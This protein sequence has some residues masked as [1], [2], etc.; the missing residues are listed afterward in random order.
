MLK[1]IIILF[2]TLCMVCSLLVG[3]NKSNN[4]HN[5]MK[6]SIGTAETQT[7]MTGDETILIG[8]SASITGSAPVNGLR[9]QQGVQLAVDEI[10]AA[11]GVLGK[12]LELF[13]ADDGGVQDTAINAINLILDQNIVAQVGPNLSGLTLAIESLMSDAGVPFLT[14][15]TSPKLVTTID[16]EYLFRIRASDSIQAKI[17]TKFI[18][19]NLGCKKIG[20]LTDSDDYGAGALGVAIEY[21]EAMGIEYE[22]QVFNTGDIDLTSQ[23]QKLIMAGVDGVI[24]WAHD[25]ETAL[26]AQ[27]FYN[28]GLD[29]PIVGSTSISTQQVIDLCEKEWLTNWYSVTDFTTTNPSEIVQEFVTNFSK[30]YNAS[31]ELYAAT[32]YSSIYILKDAIERARSTDREEIRQALLETNGFTSVLATYTTNEKRE[33]VHQGIICQIRGGQAIYLD[34]V[35]SEDNL[36]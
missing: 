15:A 4:K 36:I 22:S 19:E 26:A 30:A 1:K 34:T 7:N 18:T 16:N 2:I 28:L 5:S 17:A 3:C 14:G 31:P 33:M 12:K 21:L 27:Y 13:I 24:V 8:V 35:V 10:N 9:T 11:G 20:L 25:N 6:N 29:V 23:V 32:Y